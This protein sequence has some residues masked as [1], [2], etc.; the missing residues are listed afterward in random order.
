M[1]CGQGLQRDEGISERQ[2][3]QRV[4]VIQVAFD[5][6]DTGQ[7]AE[8]K[9][10]KNTELRYAAQNQPFMGTQPAFFFDRLGA[11][12]LLVGYLA[13]GLPPRPGGKLG[14]TPASLP[15]MPR[16]DSV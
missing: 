10:A 1:A 14:M 16:N 12:P 7:W 5:Q 4:A 8:Q 9:Q 13:H 11:D 2:D 3:I 6:P 15:G